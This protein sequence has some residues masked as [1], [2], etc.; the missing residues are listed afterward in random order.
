MSDC[1][2]AG[3]CG[4]ATCER[5][6]REALHDAMRCAAFTVPGPGPEVD[7][8]LEECDRALRAYLAIV[9]PDHVEV[10][11]PRLTYVVGLARRP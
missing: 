7:R 1:D 9:A 5:C 3:D 8:A 11:D 6:A 10:S 2:F 4:E